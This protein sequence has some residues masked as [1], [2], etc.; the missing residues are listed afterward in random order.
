MDD[1][2]YG[3]ATL[4]VMNADGS[5]LREIAPVECPIDGGRPA[6]KPVPD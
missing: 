6:W 2:P 5:D 3:R 4:H 1:F